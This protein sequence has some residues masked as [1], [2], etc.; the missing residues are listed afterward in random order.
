V[1]KLFGGVALVCAALALMLS[2][3]ALERWRP[4]H[5]GL[6]PRV[7]SSYV[8]A[9]GRYWVVVKVAGEGNARE[10]LFWNGGP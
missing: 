6:F 5:E 9:A 8:D 10:V 2:G 1:K 3:M 7:G 4:K